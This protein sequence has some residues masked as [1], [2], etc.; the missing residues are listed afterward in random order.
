M[1]KI[2]LTVGCIMITVLYMLGNTV[3]SYSLEP[4]N[5][6]SKRVVRIGYPIQDGLTMK[7]ENGS[8]Y[9]YMYDYLKE[10]SQ[11]T[12]WSYEFVEIDDESTDVQLTKLIEM[13]QNG[14]IDMLGG[15]RYSEQLAK[16]FDYPTES[17]GN[18]YSVLAVKDDNDKLDSYTLGTTKDLKVALNETSTARNEKW[19]QYAQNNG[20]KYTPVY[21]DNVYKQIEAVKKGEADAWVSVDIGLEEGFRSVAR[22]SPDPMYFA[23][24]KGKSEIVHT[25]NNGMEELNQVN[26][27]LMQ[28]L[29]FKY[30]DQK[31]ENVVLTQQ[32][33]NYIASSGVLKVMVLKEQAPVQFSRD[34]KPQGT[35]VD[36]LD[37]IS[38]K[39]GLKFKYEIV[40]T[41]DEYIK[42]LNETDANILAGI[43]YDYSINNESSINVTTTYMEAPLQMVLGE[44]INSNE[45]SNKKL[46]IRKELSVTLEDRI[47]NDNVIYCNSTKE[48]IEAVEKGE[49]DYCI[50]GTYAISY[51][52]NQDSYH[53]LISVADVSGT[54][55]NYS[56]GI[57][58]S[59][60]HLLVGI[61]N[62]CIRNLSQEEINSYIFQHS[63]EK[64]EFTLTQYMEQH[65][66]ETTVG[67]ICFIV[68]IIA[69]FSFYYRRQLEMKRQIEVEN[70]RYKMLGQITQEIIFEYDYEK[71]ILDLKG[72]KNILSED[73]EIDHYG[74][75][76]I[77]KEEYSLFY[78]LMEKKDTDQD[79]LLNLSNGEKRWYHIV[80]KVVYNLDKPVYAIGR[81]IDIQEEK[82]EREKLEK[83]SKI[84]DLTGIYN[85]SAIKKL[86]Q[87]ALISSNNIYAFGILDLDYFKH[88]NDEFGHYIGDQVLTHAAMAMQEAFGDE[89]MLGRL[90][91]DEFVVFMPENVKYEEVEKCCQI[92]QEKMSVPMKKFPPITVSMGFAIGYKEKDFNILYQQTDKV[93]YDVKETGRN[94]YK[95]IYLDSLEKDMS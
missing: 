39:T 48:C 92:M 21:Y 82:M 54:K 72:K 56:F 18:A 5:N 19:E 55:L 85:S 53:S 23:V 25:L 68:L 28:T 27:T 70:S 61:L 69:V 71:D 14:E 64:G 93:L 95:I 2:V 32:E 67:A 87:D 76:V 20:I 79:V 6:E 7:D 50:D 40:D 74:E 49:A 43:N 12:N 4:S 30:F 94:A 10:L 52:M 33:K 42:K 84:D 31:S 8:Y 17:Y 41:Y 66:V 81:L 80:M 58:Q 44:K 90:G 63:T 35:A 77:Q 89:C 45:L 16:M 62:K 29:Y 24:S 37:K 1:K 51:Y 83:E 75:S 46:A 60:D 11:Y 26:P 78:C 59:D 3:P 34:N 36:I 86:I 13:L 47:T 38:Q 22:F 88:V 65:V 15:M 9:G 91:G 73:S 57:A